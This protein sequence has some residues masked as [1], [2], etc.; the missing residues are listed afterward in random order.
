[1]SKKLHKV[2]KAF[3]NISAIV[4]GFTMLFGSLSKA[5]SVDGLLSQYVF[6]EG[7]TEIINTGKDPVRFK[8][9]Y[10]SVEDVLNGNGAIAAAA[11]AEGTVL[12][13]ND[14]NALPLNVET[15]KVSVFG[16]T[17]YD[18]MYSLDGAGEV[19]INADRQQWL[20]TELEK[21]GV[22]IN[23]DLADWYN[24]NK[25]F[26]REDYINI[27]DN[28][29]NKNGANATLN[30]ASWSDI[31]SA[32]TKAG[33]NTAIFVT[34]R[35]TNEAIDLPPLT[36]NGASGTT[37]NDYLKFSAKELDMLSNLKNNFDKVIVVF[38]QA[39]PMQE[40]LPK[41]LEQY[42]VDA[43]L[44]IGFP[45]SDGL[46]AV[47]D[48]MVGKSTPSGGLST[49][50]YTS[51]NANPSTANF[52]N[53]SN[54]VMQEDMYIGYRYAET[55]YEDVLLGAENAGEY[56]YGDNISYPFGYGL[57]Y[58]DF[59]YEIV[60]L[61][62]ND[63]PAKNYYTTGSHKGQKKPAAELRAKGSEL[64]DY[65]DLILKVKVT[66]EGDTYAGKEV[67]QVYLQ[68]PYTATS[69]SHGVQKPSVEL[70]GFG[71]TSK[72]A[73]GASETI[74]IEIDAN[75]YFASYDR[76]A[77]ENGAYVLDEG[78]YYLAAGRNSHEALNSI[79]LK[80]SA[81]GKTVNKGGMDSEYG[82]GNAA[83]VQT[84]VVDKERSENYVYWTQGGLTP[85]N[86]FDN[87][88]PNV[89]SGNANLVA[90]MNRSNWKNTAT[91]TNYDG[92][93]LSGVMNDGKFM[94]SNQKA[95]FTLENIAKY[96]PQYDQN[97]EDP[98]FGVY[99]EANAIMLADMI[100]VEYDPARG[101]SEE[102]IAKWDAFMSQ[103]T[104]EETYGLLNNGLR[105]TT[106]IEKVGKPYTNDVN[107]SNSISW[108]FDMSIQGGQGSNNVGFAYKFDPANRE[109]NPTGY[110]CEGI[111]AASFNIEVAKA[112]GQAIGEDGLWTGA[113][114][115]YGFGL[116][117]HRNPYHGRAGEYYSEDPVLTGI[118]GGYETL[119]AQSKGLYVYNK[120]FVLNDQ[121]A[122]RTGYNSWL[123]EQTFRQI[124]LRP[125]ELA[126]EIGDAMNVMT[127]F[128]RV[129]S[130]W[131]GNN[132]NLM[133]TCLRH[134]FGMAGFAVTDYWRSGGMNLTWGILAGQ[135]LPDG[136]GG[137]NDIKDFAPGTGYG[138]YTTAVRQSAQRI[139]YVVANSNAMNFI[140][141]D[142][143]IKK[144]DPEWYAIRDIVVAAA[145]GEFALSCLFVVITTFT[146]GK[147]S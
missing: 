140:G 36:S 33:Y 34:G 98:K 100:G 19:K 139:M 52:G 40:D 147:E 62:G 109:Y 102:D 112:V 21:E 35:M 120:H 96:F 90:F 87:M 20:H 25:S 108:M 133:T 84:V 121:E 71:K 119:G 99:D 10:T 42:G 59:S 18:P 47:A 136:S 72:L 105:R 138:F 28:T 144:Y 146:K 142:T 61:E 80:K 37:N 14:N 135:D 58:T 15:D 48:L 77:G 26:W 132:Y 31:S 93:A 79:L 45:G 97:Q 88:D 70:V 13:K 9:W 92:I 85:E 81:E 69:L 38:N 4:F 8:T 83:N 130:S 89:A 66:N 103:L 75:K 6:G 125:F 23:Q 111:I 50:W 129:G 137:A 12:L 118:I 57:S 145:I 78:A 55:R 127:A 68:Q 110:P 82:A 1:M 46:A 76:L 53:S 43:A 54:V 5:P 141:E 65:D 39:N 16:V 67:V 29:T 63:D 101:A 74:E 122:N 24:S 115:L 73:P 32:K 3:F 134:E 91:G 30:G 11:Q 44:W 128:N 104:W 27:Y 126:I 106:A 7:R 22:E 116:G 2:A 60:G 124:Y 86:I 51:R 64:G 95:N 17:A 41:L 113:S 114:G 49:T 56:V 107:A 131:S 143:I 117:L 94:N 123:R